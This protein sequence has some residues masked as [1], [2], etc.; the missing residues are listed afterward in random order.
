[1]LSIRYPLEFPPPSAPLHYQ[2]W[3]YVNSDICTILIIC[4][5][6]SFDNCNIT[7]FEDVA[8]YPEDEQAGPSRILI[9]V[10]KPHG[11][12]VQTLVSVI[13]TVLRIYN[14]S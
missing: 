2:R 12:P 4:K 3:N 1:M 8:R 13:Y 10:T 11:V 9:P 7:V 14:V 5:K 6:L